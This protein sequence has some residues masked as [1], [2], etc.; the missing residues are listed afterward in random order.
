MTKWTRQKN[1][2]GD[3]K[4]KSTNAPK[5]PDRRETSPTSFQS[6]SLVKNVTKNMM[7]KVHS[8]AQTFAKYLIGTGLTCL[9]AKLTDARILD[10]DFIKKLKQKLYTVHTCDTCKTFLLFA[11]SEWRQ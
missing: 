7:T 8:P 11:L 6:T 2:R 4:G 3:G 10:F 1:K 5:I 9:V